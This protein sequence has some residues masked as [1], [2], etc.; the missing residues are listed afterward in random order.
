MNKVILIGRITKDLELTYTQTNNKAVCKFTL[1]VD[2]RFDKEK[3]DFI[4]CVA[5]EKLA[6]TIAKYCT[7]GQKIA[8]EGRME[9]R[10][11]EKDGHKIYITEVICD[12][13]E[14]VD[15][16]KKETSVEQGEIKEDQEETEDLDDGLPF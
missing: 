12:S 1:A 8:V 16:K 14:F 2:R 9:I 11:Y 3:V 4:N 10:N 13:M 7:K 15:S 5:W 6:E